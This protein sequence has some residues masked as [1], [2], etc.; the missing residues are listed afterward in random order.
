M[1]LADYMLVVIVLFFIG[2]SVKKFD[3]IICTCILFFN[4]YI[5]FVHKILM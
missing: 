4:V 5:K 2:N 3:G 1:K